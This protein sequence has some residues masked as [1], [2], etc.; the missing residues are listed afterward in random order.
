MK[1]TWTHVELLN[2]VILL[3]WAAVFPAWR[4]FAHYRAYMDICV[5]FSTTALTVMTLAVIA[6][7]HRATRKEA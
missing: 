3:I 4:S 2:I 6:I 1:T 7:V 5:A